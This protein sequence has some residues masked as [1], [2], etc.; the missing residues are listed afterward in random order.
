LVKYAALAAANAWV[1]NEERG[2]PIA[3]HVMLADEA[4]VTDRA[5]AKAVTENG[6]AQGG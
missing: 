3:V 5:Q 4:G 6:W 1:I 2:P